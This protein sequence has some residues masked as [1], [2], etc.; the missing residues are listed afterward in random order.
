M[1]SQGRSFVFFFKWNPYF[2][3]THAWL[4]TWL[5]A[6]GR[7]ANTQEIPLRLTCIISSQVW[8]FI[9]PES[10]ILC[11]KMTCCD[12]KTRF[13]I[14]GLQVL[15]LSPFYFLLCQTLSCSVF[16]FRDTPPASR[17]LLSELTLQLQDTLGWSFQHRISLSI[18][19]RCQFLLL[20][21]PKGENTGKQQVCWEYSFEDT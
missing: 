18:W 8:L 6:A 9:D 2:S 10:M 14:L 21:T 7:I 16:N 11:S 4:Y 20:Q 19:S 12:K 3:S 5:P 17:L 15:V 1:S 13:L